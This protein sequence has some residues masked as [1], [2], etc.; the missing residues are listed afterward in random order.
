MNSK[1]VLKYVAN[2]YQMF[3]TR[4]YQLTE[5]MSNGCRCID[6]R[7][8]SG[9]EYTIVCDRGLDIS[10]AS[11]KGINLSYL[12]QNMEAHPAFYD[13]HGTEWLR[14]FSGGL[15]T[16]CGPT[17]IAEPCEDDGEQ[18][19]Q[20]GRWTSFPAVGVN[21]QCDPQNGE[22]QISGTLYDTF[23]LGHKLK[24]NR[25]ISSQIGKSFLVVEDSIENEGGKP[26]PL[27]VLYHVNFGYP[28]LDERAKV[29]VSSNK[30]EGYNEYSDQHLDEWRR[31]KAPS[32]NNKELNYMHTFDHKSEQGL[33]FIHNEYV[34]EGLA[35]YIK[36]NPKQLPFLTQWKYE[37][38]K[39][40][41]LALEPANAPCHP[42][43]LL[44]QN[45][46]LP[47]L[48]PGE[49]IDFK[50]E[51]GVVEGNENISQTLCD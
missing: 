42:R 43:N 47:V 8:G 3:G 29:Y 20:H 51:I 5:G 41:V 37:N 26:V 28:L 1:D 34:G 21:D 16:T 44:R 11:Y 31:V 30:C 46:M 36:F 19:G 7:T 6:V 38:V 4:H 12:T 2:N 50:V 24:I 25:K 49:K 35:V 9:L 40:Y 33:A 10:L 23:A 32:G 48:N 45:N 15:L 14:V 18:L 39:D 22:I 27:N 13:P 17:N